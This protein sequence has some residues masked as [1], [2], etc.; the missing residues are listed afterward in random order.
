MAQLDWGEWGEVPNPPGVNR[1]WERVRPCQLEWRVGQ[2]KYW[3]LG[4]WE[5]GDGAVAGVGISEKT[6][7]GC[8]NGVPDGWGG[9]H[10]WVSVGVSEM[11]GVDTPRLGGRACMMAAVAGGS[12]RKAT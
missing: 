9:C 2:K 12:L 7:V 4:C 1:K 8:G 10:I 3:D 6:S 11:G 5:G